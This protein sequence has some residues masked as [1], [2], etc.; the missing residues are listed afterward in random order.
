MVVG[1]KVWGVPHKQ[2]IHTHTYIYTIF[3]AYVTH[4]ILLMIYLIF[5]D[6]IIFKILILY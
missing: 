1:S 3:N 6:N 2:H 4:T 5:I